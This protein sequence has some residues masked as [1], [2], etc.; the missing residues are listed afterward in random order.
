[1]K[2]DWRRRLGGAGR[3]FTTGRLS[4]GPQLLRQLGL[5]GVLAGLAFLAGCAGP[6]HPQ[7]ALDPDTEYGWKLQH[8]FELILILAAIVF[9]AV[10]GVLLYTVWRFRARPGQA[11]PQQVHG[12]TVFEIGWTIA[13][14]VVLAAIAVPTVR[15]IF[16]VGGPPPADAM[17]IEV[18]GHQWWWEYRY[19][20]LNVVTAN[21]VHL[22]VSKNVSFEL[23][24]ADVI[25][26]YWIP[27]LGG[28]RDVVPTHTNHIW[29]DAP[30]QPGEYLGQC[31][32]FCGASHAN[33][34][35][36]AFVDS[37]E[38]FEAWVRNEQAPAAQPAPEVARGAQVFQSNACVGCHTIAGTNA[39]GET[40][41]NLTHVGGRT[42]LASAVLQNTPAEMARWIRDPQDVKPEALMPKLGLAEDDI[43]A[44][45]AYLE[46]L[47]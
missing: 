30:Q 36:R 17:R 19:P 29:L 32:E 3:F 20:E 41:P 23:K 13:P 43:Q 42:T 31:A 28:K 47:K 27:R 34:R 4:P 38:N 15:T 14:A 39:R 6:Y 1:V 40:G 18:I 12:N 24:S 46:S 10:E 25:H 26:S 9:V 11:R 35:T 8:L 5:A 21:E 16:D 33:M 45:A 37:Q 44:I 7:S 22:P 2:L